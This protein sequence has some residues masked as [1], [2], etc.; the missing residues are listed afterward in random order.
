[1]SDHRDIYR[2]QA[3]EYELLVSRE[4]YQK[5]LPRALSQ[6]RPFDGL[7]VVELGAGTGRL[8]SMMAPFAKAI[9]VSDISRHMLDVA[10]AKLSKTGLHNWTMTVADN[11]ALP[12]IDRAADVSIAGWSLGYFTTWYAESW[13]KEI[14]QVLAEMKRVLRPGGLLVVYDFWVNPLNPRV[15]PLRAGELRGLFAPRPVEVERVTLAPPIVRA[16]D[17]RRGLCAPLER[18]PFLRTHLLA[19]VVKEG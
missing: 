4:D 18:V 2:Q 7:D 11:R 9:L 3:N 19:A 6:I 13:R 17:G 15:R 10:I 12:V 14:G 8:T 1:M 5:N 16:L